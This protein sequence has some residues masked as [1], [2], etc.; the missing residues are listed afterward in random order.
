MLILREVSTVY[1]ILVGKFEGKTD[2]LRK[3]NIQTD[4]KEKYGPNRM[5]N[6]LIWYSTETSEY[7]SLNVRKY[8]GSKKDVEFL[9]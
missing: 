9:N 1:K 3:N 7:L 8:L 5:W 2:H 4:L 6:E